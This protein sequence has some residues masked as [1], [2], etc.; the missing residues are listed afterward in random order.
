MLQ[1]ILLEDNLHYRRG[2]EQIIHDM[3]GVSLIGSYANAESV[4][5]KIDQLK[6]DIFIVDINL[7]GISGI[8]F[9]RQAKPLLP[10]TEFLV[11]TINDDNTNIFESLKSGATGY[12][13]KESSADE[14]K[15]AIIEIAA[16]GSPMSAYISRRVIASF[17]NAATAKATPVATENL[18]E[19]EVEVL[20]HL[21]RGL[22]YK[23]IA[24]RL[25]I[26]TGTVK[27]HIRN[28]YVKLQVQNKVEAIN[29]FRA[30]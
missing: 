1:I 20:N 28:T 16:G 14:I 13:L 19:R 26:S 9:I 15:N 4:L 12:M 24:D 17:N 10:D 21:A 8:E 2:L 7:E 18:T 3:S 27:K 23:E 5:K 30:I 11:C 25:E 22:Q 6:P 29:K